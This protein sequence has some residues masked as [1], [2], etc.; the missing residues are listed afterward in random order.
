M[1]SWSGLVDLDEFR[2]FGHDVLTT[3][4]HCKSTDDFAL[5]AFPTPLL[6]YIR[7]IAFAGVSSM[8][9]PANY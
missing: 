7:E 1:A 2:R 9:S 5:Y 4:A 8:V 3:C 6:E